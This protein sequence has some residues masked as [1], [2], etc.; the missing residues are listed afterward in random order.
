MTEELLSGLATQLFGTTVVKYNPS[1]IEG[2]EKEF[3][4]APPYKRLYIIPELEKR[5]NISFENV[6]FSSDECN[7]F[8]QKICRDNG[9]NPV[10]PL[11]T[12]RLFDTLIS[13]FLEPECTQPTFIC[14]HPR[15]MS[16]LAKYHRNDSRL[17]ERFELF[18]NKK[19][20]C[21]AY[22]ELN[23]PLVQRDAFMKQMKDRDTG[24][25]EAMIIDETFMNAL[26]HGLPPTGGWGMGIDRLV[27][28]LTNKNNIKEVLLFPTMKIIKEE[29]KEKVKDDHK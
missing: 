8:L 21:N 4:F 15:I 17:T 29:V 22:T 27:M 11:T 9:I 12:P 28:F 24:D 6:D 19:E 26:E 16:P 14:D 3:N 10:P 18:V 25:D 7:Q 20:L 2:E 1:G 23:N 5:L 13:E